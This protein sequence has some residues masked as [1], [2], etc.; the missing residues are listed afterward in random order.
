[1]TMTAMNIAPRAGAR[2]GDKRD[3]VRTILTPELARLL[4]SKPHPKQRRIS[5]SVVAKYERAIRG[6]MWRDENPDPI[7]ID[8]ATGLM[9]NGGHRCTAVV[10]SGISISVLI[11]WESDAT[12][13][14][15]I[16]TGSPR[17][18]KQFVVGGNATVRTSAARVMLWHDQNFNE[19][20]TARGLFQMSEIIEKA[21]QHEALMTRLLRGSATI[22][23]RTG[24][25]QSVGLGALAIAATLGWE[26]DAQEFASGLENPGALLP[27]DPGFLLFERMARREQRSRRR[28]QMDDWKILVRYLNAQIRGEVL[29]SKLGITAMWPKVGESES[30]FRHRSG[31]PTAYGKKGTTRIAP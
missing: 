9:F 16:D 8:K 30:Q 27:H 6:G 22:Y 31:N 15:F 29:P 20:L 13:F 24:I 2:R 10:N 7:L 26:D 1:M 4:L 14:D 11:D 28:N 25:T 21:Q 18:A 19:P 23:E 5:S 3:A 17:S 12:L